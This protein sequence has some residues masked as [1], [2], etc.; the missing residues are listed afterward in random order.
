DEYQ[1]W[2]AEQESFLQRNPEYLSKVPA[3][4]KELAMLKTGLGNKE[5][6]KQN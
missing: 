6:E 5:L 3:D 2:Y 4:L 1:K